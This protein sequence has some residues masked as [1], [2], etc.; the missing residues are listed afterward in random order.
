MS[1]PAQ[2]HR[3]HADGLHDCLRDVNTSSRSAFLPRRNITIRIRMVARSQ[4]ESGSHPR[5]GCCSRTG[6]SPCY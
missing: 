4:L 2:R 1:A 5:T 3:I 6:R